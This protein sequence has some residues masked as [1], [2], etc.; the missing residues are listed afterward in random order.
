MPLALGGP[1][2]LEQD[3]EGCTQEGL[4]FGRRGDSN[5]LAIATRL[6]VLAA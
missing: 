3:S 1:L 5:G 4:S 2:R 6:G